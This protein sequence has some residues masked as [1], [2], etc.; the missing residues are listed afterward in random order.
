[1]T[2]P[3]HEDNFDE[4]DKK[5][6]EQ[7]SDGWT[8][9]LKTNFLNA[10]GVMG[11]SNS[12][13]T[14][15]DDKFTPVPRRTNSRGGNQPRW[16]RD[17]GTHPITRGHSTSSGVSRLYTLEETGE[18]MGRVH[19]RGLDPYNA[20]YASPKP[21]RST[22]GLSTLDGRQSIYPGIDNVV[23]RESQAPLLSQEVP[24]ASARP[25]RWTAKRINER[26]DALSRM[27]TGSI[28]SA[29]SV[30]PNPYNRRAAS[31]PSGLQSFTPKTTPHSGG[32]D[33]A[34]RKVR[35]KRR[36]RVHGRP[37]LMERASSSTSSIM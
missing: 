36:E 25:R 14:D 37:K 28:Y 22:L 30:G 3:G 5:K 2:P 24:T 15:E 13:G 12:S 35:S 19:I 4:V 16:N 11:K 7:G 31:N 27:S 1:M 29:E 26:P 8:S 34:Q 21:S 33:P 10:L 20:D 23:T 6:T 17:F 32:Q 9:T 18:G